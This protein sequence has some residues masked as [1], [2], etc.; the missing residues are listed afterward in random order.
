MRIEQE[1][2]MPLE[3]GLQERNETVRLSNVF[4]YEKHYCCLTDPWK[5]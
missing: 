1:D 5:D 2:K 3:G 4:E